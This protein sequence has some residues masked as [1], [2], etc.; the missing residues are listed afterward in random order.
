MED[1]RRAAIGLRWA[2]FLADIIGIM[3]LGVLLGRPLQEIEDALGLVRVVSIDTTGDAFMIIILALWG[4]AWTYPWIEIISGASPGKW[5]VGLRVLRLDGRKAGLGRRLIRAVL[6]NCALFVVLP[7]G[8]V[9]STAAI[10]AC[11]A[12]SLFTLVG[13]FFMFG[14]DRRTLYDKISGAAV[15]RPSR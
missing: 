3:I 12:V 11:F 9:E 4:G 10:A 14:P 7:F 2:A 5:L 1:S 13:M 6:K 8:I 15:I